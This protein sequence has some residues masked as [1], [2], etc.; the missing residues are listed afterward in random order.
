[1]S[2]FGATFAVDC[3]AVPT[4]AFVCATFDFTG[5]AFRVLCAGT[6]AFASCA[7]LATGFKI[8]CRGPLGTGDTSPTVLALLPGAAGR[9]IPARINKNRHAVSA[10][11][12]TPAPSRNRIERKL[13]LKVLPVNCIWFLPNGWLSDDGNTVPDFRA[14]KRCLGMKDWNKKER[15][16]HYHLRQIDRYTSRSEKK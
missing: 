16:R 13:K 5:A 8:G 6:A 2:S 1:M 12:P 9:P 10:A 7:P 15:C 11:A 4:G 3:V 14:D